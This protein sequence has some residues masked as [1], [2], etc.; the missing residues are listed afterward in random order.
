MCYILVFPFG[1]L[2]YKG[3]HSLQCYETIWK[4]TGCQATGLMYPANWTA[5]QDALF[6]TY[7]LRLFLTFFS[8]LR[9]VETARF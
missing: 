7:N 2:F 8:L 1:C 3:P 9:S 5:A 6:D 4:E